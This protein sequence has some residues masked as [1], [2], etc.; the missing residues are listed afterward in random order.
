MKC[1]IPYQHNQYAIPVRPPVIRSKH[2]QMTRQC[3]PNMGG[4]RNPGTGYLTYIS[5]TGPIV[6]T[7]G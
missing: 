6:Y 3:W 2:S 4:M 7:A 1:R 5:A